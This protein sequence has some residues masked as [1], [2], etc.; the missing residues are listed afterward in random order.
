[1]PVMTLVLIVAALWV[2]IGLTLAVVMGRRGYDLA[3]W[4]VIGPVFG[5][6]A[7]AIAVLDSPRGA[8]GPEP[9]PHSMHRTDALVGIDG[10]EQSIAALQGTEELLGSSLGRL[11][12]ATV[13]PFDATPL[14]R[15]EASE[16][17]QH[18]AAVA[19]S[20]SV[21]R[22]ILQGVPVDALREY[23]TQGG[24]DVLAVGTTGRGLTTALVGSVATGL[25]HRTR[26]PVLLFSGGT[27]GDVQPA[28]P[29]TA[30][31]QTLGL[32]ASADRRAAVR[33][34]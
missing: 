31:S 28:A 13:V 21:E 3:A 34:P 26:V 16:V 20:S 5:P 12:I 18:A 29:D 23:A 4:L 14:S 2:G 9:S 25:A 27:P 7:I 11:S 30:D 6:F 8:I 24:Y 22:I 17:L 32:V 1:M 19:R 10:S 33:R 15:D